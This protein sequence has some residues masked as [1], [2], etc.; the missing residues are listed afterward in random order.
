MT[1]KQIK[2]EPKTLNQISDIIKH[3]DGNQLVKKAI[4]D[5]IENLWVNISSSESSLVLIEK[6]SEEINP[7]PEFQ[8][9][10]KN[11]TGTKG[12]YLATKF[13]KS[14]IGLSEGVY[15]LSDSTIIPVSWVEVKKSSYSL[16]T[17]F[18]ITFIILN[19]IQSLILV[20]LII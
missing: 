2:V 18:Y 13:C 11:L 17:L 3:D 4:V 6:I 10:I 15:Q 19:I 20:I 9:K 14:H 7:K 12:P 16:K 5:S 1:L 8:N